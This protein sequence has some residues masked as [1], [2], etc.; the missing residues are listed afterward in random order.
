L[1]ASYTWS[2]D[3]QFWSHLSLEDQIKQAIEDL[4][5]LHPQIKGRDIV[6]GGASVMWHTMEH[7]GGGFA[8]FNPAQEQRLHQV[9]KRPEGRIHFAGEHTSLDHRWIEGAIESGI[10]T[11]FEVHAS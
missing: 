7:F 11:A 3:A 2:R 8:L 9:I 4:E 5:R 10:R 6:E 1:L